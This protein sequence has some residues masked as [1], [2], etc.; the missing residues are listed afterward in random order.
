MMDAAR[1]NWCAGQHDAAG[2]FNFGRLPT[3]G[4]LSVFLPGDVIAVALS[5]ETQEDEIRAAL[6]GWAVEITHAPET[7]DRFIRAAKQ[8]SQRRE[9]KHSQ[10][11]A[12][13]E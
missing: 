11:T 10:A 2:V 12:H 4:E 7:H 3:A 5:E 6:D 13:G 8:S 9:R 1:Q